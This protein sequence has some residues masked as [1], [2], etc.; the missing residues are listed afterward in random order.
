MTPPEQG[1][2]HS[3]VPFLPAFYGVVGG[4]GAFGFGGFSTWAALVQAAMA[5]GLFAA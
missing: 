2:V 4:V 5:P 1:G 3:Y